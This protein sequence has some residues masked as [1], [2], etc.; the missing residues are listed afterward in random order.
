MKDYIAP[1]RRPPR[2]NAWNGG[3]DGNLRFAGTRKELF[4]LM[5]F[6]FAGAVILYVYTLLILV[7]FG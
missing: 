4:K 7:A 6:S 3:I 2:R 5:I 1:I